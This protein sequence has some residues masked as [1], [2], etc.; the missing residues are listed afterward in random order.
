VNPNVEQWRAIVTGG[1]HGLGRAVVADLRAHGANAVVLDRAETGDRGDVIVDLAD[2]RDAAYATAAAIDR[3]GGLDVLV[4]CA[5]IDVPGDL[6]HVAFDDWRRVVDVNLVA[7]AAVVQAAVPALEQAGGRIVTVA[8][9]LGHRGAAGATAYCASKFAVVGFTR[10]L[11]V[12]LR[13]RVGVTL[14][15]P[16][17]MD[18]SFFD[19]RDPQFQPPPDLR[20]ADPGLVAEAVRFVLSRP[21]GVEVKE[22][23]VAGPNESTWP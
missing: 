21:D 4:T 12:E 9:T 13:E 17:G 14:L 3:L 19:G 23:V 5:G 22:L 16:G 10:A 7:T 15:T 2:A 11:M 20:L 18:T 6:D 8:S 1:A